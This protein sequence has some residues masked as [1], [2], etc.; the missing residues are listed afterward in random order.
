VSDNNFLSNLYSA[1][2]KTIFFKV[3]VLSDLNIDINYEAETSSV[4]CVGDSCCHA[5]TPARGETDKAPMYG[6]T[7]CNMPLAAYNKIIDLLHSENNTATGAF[8]AASIFNLGSSNAFE[9]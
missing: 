6:S 8:A 7:K 5:D 4:N 2:A 9:P 3:G 1:T